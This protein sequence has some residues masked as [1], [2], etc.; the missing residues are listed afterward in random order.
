M[1]N[2]GR[3]CVRLCTLVQTDLT[4]SCS[5]FYLREV[6]L[7]LFF[8]SIVRCVCAGAHVLLAVREENLCESG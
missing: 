8:K 2:R 6:P 1:C 5:G 3:K 7:I 4:W